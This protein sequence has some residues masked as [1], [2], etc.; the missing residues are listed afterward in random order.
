VRLAHAAHGLP[1][2]PLW[3]VSVALRAPRT[4]RPVALLYWTADTRR[5]VEA[6]ARAAL[7]GVGDAGSEHWERGVIALHLRRAMTPAEAEG[8]RAPIVARYGEAH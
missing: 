3:H 5:R 2:W 1:Q 7:G 8:L 4:G 6:A